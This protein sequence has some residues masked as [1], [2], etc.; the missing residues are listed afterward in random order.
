MKMY[1]KKEGS[2]I[3]AWNGPSVGRTAMLEA[4]WMLYEGTLPTSRLDIQDG[5]IVELPEPDPSPEQIAFAVL[6]EMTVK[7]AMTAIPEN[8]DQT[9]LQ[10]APICPQWVAG[11]HYSAGEI[12][13]YNNQAYRVVQAVDSI[14]SQ[15]PGADGM[16][17]IYRPLS[18]SQEEAGTQNNPIAF[19]NGMDVYTG[20]YYSFNEKTYLA[21]AD[22]IPCI[23]DPGTAGVWQWEEV[24]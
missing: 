14:E 21:K 6:E 8:D 9:A 7:A 20:K 24:K 10:M 12:V 5:E 13:N 3:V 16:L 2:S 17:A 22:M 19:V 18:N 15:T 23:W 1:I 11:K 4:G